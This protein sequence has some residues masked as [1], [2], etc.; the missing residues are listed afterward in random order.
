LVCSRIKLVHHIHRYM[1]AKPPAGTKLRERYQSF[2]TDGP[3]IF[4]RTDTLTQLRQK[5]GVRKFNPPSS[6][7]GSGM[8][9]LGR[10]EPVYYRE[11]VNDPSE[12]VQTWLDN[13]DV[14]LI[15]T[16]SLHHRIARCGSEFKQASREILGPFSVGGDNGGDGSID[17]DDCPLCGDGLSGD[18]AGHLRNDCTEK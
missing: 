2:E 14:S 4:D 17:M 16:W 13:N 9:G 15:S 10:T 5:Y 12:I 6:G 3:Q 1:R 8:G 11:Q 18:L 7:R